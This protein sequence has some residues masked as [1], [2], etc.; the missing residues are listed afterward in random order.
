MKIQS[1]IHLVH[2][3]IFAC[4][5]SSSAFAQQ[6]QFAKIGAQ[7]YAL[8]RQL[9][10]EPA[11]PKL[12]IHG[13]PA[14]VDLTR[15]FTWLEQREN[16]AYLGKQL[17]SMKAKYLQ[18]MEDYSPMQSPR[19]RIRMDS[20][21]W[22]K[23]TNEDRKD[24]GRVFSG[25]GEWENVA[26][27][28]Y[29]PPLGHAFT[30]YK[31]EIILADS[32]FENGSLFFCFKGVDYKAEVYFNNQYLGFHEGF[33][34][35][36]EFDITPF[37]EK[38]LNTVVV[39]VYNEPTTT[40][41]ADGLGNHL[42]G[43]KIYAA[44]GP[45]Y[46]D[47]DEGWH[48]CPPAMGIYQDCYIE[49]RATI[50][51]RDIFVRP[52]PEK[53]IA[54]I[55]LEVNNASLQPQRISLNL[56]LL[57]KNFIDTVFTDK[58][59]LPS[60]TI[61]PGIGDMVKPS[62]WQVKELNMDYG[63]NYLRIPL[64]LKE[65]RWWH[66]DHPWLY[67]LHVGLNVGDKKQQDAQAV[68]FG[69]R[70]F[71]MDTITK[72]KGRMYLNG[73]AI[74]L[75]GANSM[76]FEQQDV[77][78]K[79]WNQLVEDILLARLCNMNFFRFTQRPVQP[80]VY[81]FCDRL[82]MLNQSDLP[83]FGAIRINQFS[84]AVKQAEEMER[85][86]RSHPSAIMVTYINER[87]PNAEGSPHR[88][89]ASVA[90]I[91]AVFKALD[92]AV[93]LSNPDRVI[94]PGDG[95]YDPPAPGLPDN[96]CYNTWYN[97]HALDLGKFHK[98]YWQLIKPDWFYGCGEYGAEGL[99][100][101]N[102]MQK[103]YPKNWLPQSSQDNLAWSPSRI[104]KAQSANMHLMWYP[105]PQGIETWIRESQ[106]YQRWAVKFVTEALRRD[107]RNVSSAVH[108][109]I[110]A[111]PAGWMKA[112]MD[113]DRQPKPAYFAYQNALAPL[114]VSLRTDR[115]YWTAG[116]V[117]QVE[118]WVCNDKPE[119]PLGYT[120]GYEVIVDGKVLVRQS[121]PVNI[122]S[123]SSLYH[124]NIQFKIPL[125]KTRTIATVRAGLF[126][127]E[128]Q[129]IHVNEQ[130]LILFPSGKPQQQKAFVL[131]DPEGK[132]KQFAAEAGI[133]E[134]K[135]LKSAKLVIIDDYHQ[136]AN[137]KKEWDAYV[138]AGGKILFTTLPTGQFT[139]GNSTVTVQPTIM[140]KYFFANPTPAILSKKILES[141]DI[142]MW[143]DK[144]KGYIQP[145]LDRVFSA[146][147]WMP[148]ITT[149]LCNF[150]GNDPNGYLAAASYKMGKGKFVLNVLQLSGMM[151]D[152]PPAKF[153]LQTMIKQQ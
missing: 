110:D 80:E 99:D 114:M 125:V 46:N 9:L 26:I 140:G 118:A 49:S 7:E 13:L 134:T 59:Y 10:I 93:L 71:Q 144:S 28:H 39:K 4:L 61:V 57:G 117:G 44:G 58:I 146:D 109:F 54:E 123:S 131:D 142:F 94:K 143:Y 3:F 103:Y 95:D 69:M 152:N 108:L 56:S 105:T 21:M 14:G 121:V 77:I 33:F 24:I 116:E 151:E 87:F 8:Q 98:G 112:I 119:I 78:K 35:P 40:G 37:A 32:M 130:E 52:Q 96:H 43:D 50:F 88:S 68:H 115:Y 51:I 17:D 100:P 30:F 67:N 91:H 70:S 145:M 85:L 63:V 137:K 79:D 5:L 20:M 153:L 66:P 90:D 12:D 27:P 31:K 89:F 34:A 120:L 135:D 22:K 76:G 136:Y 122:P 75:R 1:Y 16:K 36:F 128:G 141:K 82:G 101:L 47:P 18:F 11:P 139:I 138:H 149:G 6:D 106:E 25:V 84:Q 60:T 73:K 127:P 2:T 104:A 97:G 102:T 150:G 15:K 132:G 124:G 74:R 62:D 19:K 64:E 53:G 45:G 55:W 126:T 133:P 23:G 38:G 42:V 72:P 147:G 41:S 29:G 81:D 107:S 65:F 92:Q 86:I 111:W 129:C 113:V 48:I 83:F 148:L